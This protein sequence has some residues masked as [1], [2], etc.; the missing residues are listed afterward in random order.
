MK[1]CVALATV[2]PPGEVASLSMSEA[3]ANVILKQLFDLVET[4]ELIIKISVRRSRSLPWP[5][6]IL[7]KPY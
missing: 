2:L 4:R 1:L 3:S 7:R 6:P 5:G